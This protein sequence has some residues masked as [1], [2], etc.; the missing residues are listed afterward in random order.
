MI[1]L[2]SLLFENKI[3]VPRR[4]PEEREKTLI[5]EHYRFIQRYIRE[6][7]RGDLNL[8]RSPMK[9]LPDN[10]THVGGDLSLINS[11]IEDLNNLERIDGWLNLYECNNL[12]SFGKL[13]EVKG[14]IDLSHTSITKIP[15]FIVNVNGDLGLNELEIEDLNN[16]ERVNG[17]LYLSYTSNLKSLGN[18]KYVRGNLYLEKSNIL[19]IMTIKDIRRQVQIGGSIIHD[20]I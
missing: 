19:K 20:K 15:D 8:T 1:K 14:Y 17:T 10:L 16:V 2:K 9:I 11:K 18:L 5:A 13:R 3:L 12:K 4:S 6:G 7:C